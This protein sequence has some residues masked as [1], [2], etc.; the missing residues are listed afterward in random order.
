MNVHKST[1]QPLIFGCIVIRVHEFNAF[2]MLVGMVIK[3]TSTFD[4]LLVRCSTGVTGNS[5]PPPPPPIFGSG[6]PSSLGNSVPP[7]TEIP[8]E[9]GPP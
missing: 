5:V 2:C 9:L 8:R 7:R 4:R 3:E 1:Q 6:G